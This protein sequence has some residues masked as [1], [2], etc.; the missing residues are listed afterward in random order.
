MWPHAAPEIQRV[1]DLPR[2][3]FDHANHT[4]ICAGLAH[5]GVS[6]DWHEREFPIARRHDFM[7]G[8]TFLIHGRNLFPG[9]RI[10][11]TKSVIT[12]VADKQHTASRRFRCVSCGGLATC[13]DACDKQ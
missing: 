6:K 4:T 10:N 8:H 3:H 9:N 7:S 12:F 1:H 2:C 13:K 5:A 11:D